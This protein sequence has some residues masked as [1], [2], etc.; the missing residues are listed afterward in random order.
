M[1]DHG[2]T[3]DACITGGFRQAVRRRCKDDSLAASSLLAVE[4]SIHRRLGSYDSVGLF[5]CPSNFLRDTM[6]RGGID[7]RR[8]R[9]VP[10]FV[11]LSAAV[12][13]TSP[14]GPVLYVGRLSEEKGVDVLLLAAR[15]LSPATTVRIVGDGPARSELEAIAASGGGA[16]VEFAGHVSPDQVRRHLAEASV[17]VIPSRCN[18]NQP[19]AALEALAAGVPVVGSEVG[20]LPELIRPGIDGSLVGPNDQQQLARVLSSFIEDPDL[21]FDLG[22]AGRRRAEEEFGP[23]RHLENVH[24]LYG[25]LLRGDEGAGSHDRR[26]RSA[27]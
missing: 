10:N 14:G 1:L 21:A 23:A 17:L 19:L 7:P 18:E 25:S 11:D 15:L 2:R 3:C 6:E 26:A 4:S 9:V 24:D 8:L 16:T 20:G 22:R 12:R 27:G 5:S 13:K